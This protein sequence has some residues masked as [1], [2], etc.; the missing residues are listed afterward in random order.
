M[1]TILSTI[2]RPA[3]ARRPGAIARL[4]NACVGGIV[5]YFA[6]RAAIKSLH[7]LDDAAL[8]DIGL[9]R[10]QIEPAVY[11]SISPFDRARMG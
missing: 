5:R 2:A 3:I 7:E 10:S 6:C 8:R 9:R 11:G 4:F 1:S